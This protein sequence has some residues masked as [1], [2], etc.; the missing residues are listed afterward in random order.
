M[1]HISVKMFPGRDE[2]VKQDLADKLHELAV[3]ELGCPEGAVSV[4]VEDVEKENWNGEVLDKIAD[5][6]ML[7]KP[8]Y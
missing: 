1:P 8:N 6:D 7:V 3:K 4:S 5:K 2:K